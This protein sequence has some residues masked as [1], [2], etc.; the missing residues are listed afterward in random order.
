MELPTSSIKSTNCSYFLTPSEGESL[1]NCHLFTSATMISTDSITF[2]DESPVC[3]RQDLLHSSPDSIDSIFSDP[4]H[5]PYPAAK[6]TPPTVN[7]E[8]LPLHVWDR[9]TSESS[10]TSGSILFFSDD[11]S[12]SDDLTQTN[13]YSGTFSSTP[14]R[15]SELE[16][17]SILP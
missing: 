10:H 16:E 6:S 9:F 15:S 13:S 2:L 12:D 14:V 5:P 11:D 1:D 17:N 4:H 7:E 8:P 3:S